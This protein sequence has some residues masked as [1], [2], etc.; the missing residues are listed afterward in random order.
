MAPPLASRCV[1]LVFRVDPRCPAVFRGSVSRFPYGL[2][3][4]SV[5]FGVLLRLARGVPR[6]AAVS[7]GILAPRHDS[8]CPVMPHGVQRCDVVSRG[9]S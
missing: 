5:V 8:W 6:C 4:C 7:R 2:P 3:W 9:V 1:F